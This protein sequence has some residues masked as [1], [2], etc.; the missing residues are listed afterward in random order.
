M[1]TMNLIEPAPVMRDGTGCWW[2]PDMPE[3]EEGQGDE[4]RA[5]QAEQQLDLR[6]ACLDGEDMDHPVYIAVFDEGGCDFSAWEPTAPAGEGWFTL[7]IGD[8]EDGPQWC[9]ARRMA[10]EAV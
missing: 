10:P 9:W 1:S 7:C 2:H 4:W 3:F 5:W 8:T 6:Y